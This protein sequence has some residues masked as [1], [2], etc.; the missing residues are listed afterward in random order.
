[1]YI[2]YVIAELL[3]AEYQYTNYDSAVNP[4][5]Y[6]KNIKPWKTR[7]KGVFTVHKKLGL[8][9]GNQKLVSEIWLKDSFTQLENYLEDYLCLKEKLCSNSSTLQDLLKIIKTQ[10]QGV[11]DAFFKSVC[12]PELDQIL[13]NITEIIDKYYDVGYCNF[14]DIKELVSVINDFLLITR[15]ENKTKFDDMVDKLV[16]ILNIEQNYQ[17]QCF[18]GRDLSK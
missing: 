8:S 6:D 13:N 1:M 9:K 4:E 5:Y 10:N 11:K 7:E 16:G 15:Y 3:A 18:T 14:K 17:D 2:Y 12:D